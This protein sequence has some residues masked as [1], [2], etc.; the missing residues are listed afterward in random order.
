MNI[1]SP[2]VAPIV[3]LHIAAEKVCAVEVTT[4]KNGIAFW[5]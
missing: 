2:D 4:E 1:L 5:K 3:I